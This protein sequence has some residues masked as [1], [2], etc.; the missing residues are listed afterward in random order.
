LGV[1]VDGVDGV[2][3]AGG[4]VAEGVEV[5]GVVPGGG[6][7]LEL[8]VVGVVVGAAGVIGVPELVDGLGVLTFGSV[9]DLPVVAPG[10]VLAAGG[11][12]VAAGGG[13]VAAGGV[14]AGGTCAWVEVDPV[15]EP[16]SLIAA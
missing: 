14:T 1:V 8:D 2:V 10:P 6:E 4:V 5:V 13:V 9:E 7:T 15:V 12:V 16:L 11:V 3:P